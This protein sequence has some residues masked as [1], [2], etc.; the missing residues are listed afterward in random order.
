MTKEYLK[1]KQIYTM[2]ISVLKNI[3]IDIHEKRQSIPAC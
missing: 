3:I 1:K 2:I